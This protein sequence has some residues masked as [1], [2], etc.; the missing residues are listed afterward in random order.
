[1]QHRTSRGFTLVEIMIVV[2]ILGILGAVVMGRYLNSTAS[3][4]D[5]HART[6][7][8]S[9]QNGISMYQASYKRVPSYF[10]NWVAVSDG[11]S[12]RNFV[13]IDGSVRTML[14]HPDAEVLTNNGRTL[15]LTYKNGLVA[16]YVLDPDA[17]TI[18]ATYTEP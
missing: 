1:M 15:T 13:R 12:K 11:G 18:T 9:L 2:V 4:Y 14:S 6:L 5:A 17:G 10:W 7:E 8:K 16:S 3:A